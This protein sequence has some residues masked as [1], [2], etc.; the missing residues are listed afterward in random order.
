MRSTRD[1]EAFSIPIS[2]ADYGRA[3]WPSM[4][5]L[6]Q[7]HV[8]AH[9]EPQSRLNVELLPFKISTSKSDEY[10]ARG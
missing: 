6:C 7:S 4:A 2:V 9:H 1:P 3:N 8:C 10:P 5:A